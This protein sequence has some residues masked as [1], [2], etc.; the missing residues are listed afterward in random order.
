MS[1]LGMWSV[2]GFM[3]T[4]KPAASTIARPGTAVRGRF[5]SPVNG[6]SG[7][8]HMI[9]VPCFQWLEGWM[10]QR[11]AQIPPQPRLM[12]K[13][14]RLAVTLGEAREDAN[15]FGRTLSTEHGILLEEGVEIE[16]T[17]ARSP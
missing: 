12:L 1:G 15:H 5:R 10:R 13:I 3:R 7:R 8:G 6:E 11:S 16:P 17:I 4:P 9:V 2:S 14:L